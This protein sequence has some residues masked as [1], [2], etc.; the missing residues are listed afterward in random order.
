M[1]AESLSPPQLDEK[2]LIRAYFAL[3]LLRRLHKEAARTGSPIASMLR[4]LVDEALQS[5][6]AHRA[7]NCGPKV[8]A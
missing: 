2:K 5:R 6:E 1:N 8:G 3:P 7:V 4:T